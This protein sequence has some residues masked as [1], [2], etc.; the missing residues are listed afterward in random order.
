MFY[1]LFEHSCSS[2]FQADPHLDTTIDAFWK[3][4]NRAQMTNRVG[5]NRRTD[6]E[7]SEQDNNFQLWN[8]ILFLW[9]PKN[10]LAFEINAQ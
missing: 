3:I 5:Q 1:G 7:V 8:K 6:G 10:I 2:D 9:F 4:L